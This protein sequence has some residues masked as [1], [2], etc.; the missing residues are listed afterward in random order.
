VA[1]DVP[2]DSEVFLLTD[3][4]NL[5]IKSAQPSRGDHRGEV[6]ICV[7]SDKCSYIYEYLYLYYIKKAIAKSIKIPLFWY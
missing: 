1:D 6:Y 7:Y 4:I 2:V 3:F 5:K